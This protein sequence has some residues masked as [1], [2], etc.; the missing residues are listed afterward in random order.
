MMAAIKANVKPGNFL[1][2]HLRAANDI[3]FKKA[4]E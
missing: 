4:V 3:A 1:P 2:F